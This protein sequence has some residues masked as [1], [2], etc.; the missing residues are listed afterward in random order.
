MTALRKWISELMIYDADDKLS[1]D[2]AMQFLESNKFGAW[3]VDAQGIKGANE[4]GDV[5][6]GYVNIK[7]ISFSTHGFPGGVYFKNGSLVAGNLKDV[8]IPKDLFAGQGRVLF[9]GCETARTKVGE[10]FLVAA[11]R[12]FFAGKGGVVGGSTVYNYGFSSGTRLPVLGGSSSDGF[13]PEIGHLVLVY[14][15]AAGNIVSHKTVK[16]F[17][18]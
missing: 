18:F 5:L 2:E 9:M 3:T 7:Q 17:G 8:S 15:D 13:L 14:L 1:S 12:Q 11:G 6:K 4:L 10:H 16:P